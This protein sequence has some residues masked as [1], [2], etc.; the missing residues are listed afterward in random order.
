M[1]RAVDRT[2]QEGRQATLPPHISSLLGI[3]AEKE[4]PVIQGVVRAEKTVRGFDVSVANKDDVVLFV[5]NETTNDQFL[6]L[7]SRE[8]SLRKVVSVKSGM[9]EI[10]QITA[11]GKKSFEKEKQFWLDLLA[12]VSPSK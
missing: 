3:S 4:S 2:L 11:E 5:V 7:T 1:V 8:G 6:Y 10:V 12:P 9:G